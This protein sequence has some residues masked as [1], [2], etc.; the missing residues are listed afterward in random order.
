[1]L[2][3]RRRFDGYNTIVVSPQAIDRPERQRVDQP[4]H[5]GRRTFRPN[6]IYHQVVA[7]Q[8]RSR[9]VAIDQLE[10]VA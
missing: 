5:E 6:W 8:R 1:M 10:V 7:R 3:Q 4:A 2:R 9:R